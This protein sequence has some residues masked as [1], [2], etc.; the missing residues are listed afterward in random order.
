MILNVPYR[1]TVSIS[2]ILTVILIS[3]KSPAHQEARIVDPPAILATQITADNAMQLV[4]QGPDAAGGIG[5]WFLSNG[6]LCAVISNVDHESD[7][8]VKGGVLIDL[9]FCDR[10]DDQYVAAQDLIDGSRM[11]PVDIDRID[12]AMGTD[13]ASITTFGGRGSIVVET[14]YTLSTS[15]ADRL[16]ISKTI[17]RISDT[18]DGFGVYLSVGFNYESMEVFLLASQNLQLSN[19][20]KQEDF[21]DRGLMAFD[22]AARKADTI[23]TISPRHSVVPIS[24]GWRIKSAVKSADG[25]SSALPF[26]ALADSA[27]TAFIVLSEDFFF[28]D[29]DQP[30]IFQLLQV[31]LMELEVHQSITIE[32]E[33]IVSGGSD[34]A[35]ITDKIFAEENMLAGRVEEEAVIHLDMMDGTPFTHI[36]PD[37]QGIFSARAPKGEY[38]LR[39]L[40]PGGRELTKDISMGDADIG[41]GLIGLPAPARVILPSGKAMRLVFRGKGTTPDPDFQDPL[42]GFSVTDNDGIREKGG[43]SSVFLAGIA[44]DKAFVDLAP[45]QYHVYATRGIEFTLEKAEI[46]VRE[47]EQVRLDIKEPQRAIRSDGFIAADFHV[48]SGPSMDNGLSTVERLRTFVAEHG[49]V[50]VASEHDTVFSFH[51]LVKE[52]ELGEKIAT[53]TGTEMTSEVPSAR[54]PHTIGHANFFPLEPQP[55]AFR[56]GAPNGENRRMREVISEM[57]HRNPDIVSQLNHARESLALSGELDDDFESKINNQSYLDH[58]GPASFPYQ[59][60]KVITSFPN[61]TLLEPDP[62]TGVRD[63]DFDVMEIMNGAQGNSTRVAALR[64]DWLSFLKQ[65]IRIVGS[66]NSDSHTMKSQ[67]GLPRNMIG[68]TDDSLAGFDIDIFTTAIKQG[69]LYGTTGPLLALKLADIAMGGL[70]HISRGRLEV[71]VSAADWVPVDTISVQVNGITVATRPVDGSGEFYFDLDFSE[72]A[73]VTIEVHGQAGTDYQAVYPFFTPYAFSNPIYVDADGDGQWTAPGL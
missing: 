42:T 41:L 44:S 58:M 32:E 57:Q 33:I 50:M 7:L 19:G 36:H 45:G 56:R 13:S 51:E 29:N 60:G 39:L 49:E 43:V 30:G 23:I 2:L 3:S 25:K 66:A 61:S 18:S 35:S 63:I 10:A 71:R 40:T 31:A 37:E 64:L 4:Q 72:D 48:H 14:R 8:S 70:A 59:P 20:F 1:A 26:F 55:Y 11:S 62:V 5:D 46:A 73:F 68:V 21:V 53:V 54:V 9:G 38:Q 16:K 17:R 12:V 24:Y 67:V 34:V 65:G 47:G 27:S 69:N 22:R 6:T 15:Q 28:A 52:L